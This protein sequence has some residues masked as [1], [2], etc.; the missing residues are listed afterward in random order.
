MN[1][2]EI[3]MNVVKSNS[4]LNGMFITFYRTQRGAHFT[5]GEEDGKSISDKYIEKRWIYVYNPMV[6]A[7]LNDHGAGATGASGGFGFATKNVNI[8]RQVQVHSKKYPE[9]ESQ[10]LSEHWHFL[11][12]FLSCMN[13]DQD[14][15][16][17][18]IHEQ[19]RSDKFLIGISFEKMSEAN[20]TGI[21]EN[22][23]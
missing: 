2:T 21:N 15:C 10:S 12:R 14:A 3:A 22:M 5:N 1:G 7:R 19:Y 8:S 4:T 6:H 9:F 20:R 17:I 23:S 18:I 11:N 13:P 16:S